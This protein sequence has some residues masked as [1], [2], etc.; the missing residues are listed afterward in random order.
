M[1]FLSTKAKYVYNCHMQL[2]AKETVKLLMSRSAMTQKK[3]AKI[4]TEVS[5]RTYTTSSLSHKLGRGTI[6]YDEVIQ[7][8]DI[9][10]YKVNI[11]QKD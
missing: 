10:G 3:L 8:F 7:I 9:L 5:G 2:N 11:V 4:L 1:P 6:S